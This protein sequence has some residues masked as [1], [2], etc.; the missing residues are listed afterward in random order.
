MMTHKKP[1]KRQNNCG[2]GFFDDIKIEHLTF[3]DIELERLAKSF[4]DFPLPNIDDIPYNFEGTGM[5]ENKELGRIIAGIKCY[6]ANDLVG[7]L[8]LALPTIKKHIQTGYIKAL[9][10]GKEYIITEPNLQEFLNES[11][12]AKKNKEGLKI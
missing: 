7:M 4:F 2:G 6:S 1:K 10:V 3:T 12:T 9:K 5:T 11:H 8:N